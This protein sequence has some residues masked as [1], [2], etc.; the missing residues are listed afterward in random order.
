MTN[1][2]APPRASCAGHPAK[3]AVARSAAMLTHL[4]AA[5]AV[6]TVAPLVLG[7]LLPVPAG[8]S[9]GDPVSALLLLSA[10]SL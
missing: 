1:S 5:A 6:L 4:A 9:T 8:L 7:S 10:V 2:D 3:Q